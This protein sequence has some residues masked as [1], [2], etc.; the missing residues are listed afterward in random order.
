MATPTPRAYQYT[1]LGVTL[2]NSDGP[3]EEQTFLMLMRSQVDIPGYL[4]EQEPVR[5]SHG[6]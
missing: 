1:M 2:A 3:G 6:Y 4:D 5:I